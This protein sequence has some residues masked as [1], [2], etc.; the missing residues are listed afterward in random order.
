MGTDLDPG[1]VEEFDAFV[2][3]RGPRLVRIAR[4]LVDD[5]DAADD[6]VQTVLVKVLDAWP[7]I[8]R[9]QDRDAYLRRCLVNTRNSWWWRRRREVRVEEVTDALTAPAGDVA[10]HVVRR[11]ALAA[12]LRRL[13]PGQRTA[14]VLRYYADLDERQVADAMGCSVGTVRSQTGRGLHRLREAL[15]AVPGDESP[16]PTPRRP[17]PRAVSP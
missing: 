2:R 8:R 9:V 16:A 5:A 3:S 10:E 6:L 11:R 7:R 1:L 4:L 14:V 13:S 15:G 12:A 17:R